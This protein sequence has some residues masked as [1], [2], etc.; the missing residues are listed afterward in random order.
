MAN[1][2]RVTSIS[3]VPITIDANTA[4][5]YTC[6]S[7]TTTVVLALLI[8]NKHTVAVGASVQLVSNTNN[9]GNNNNIGPNA[10]AFIIKDVTIDEKTSLEIMAGQKYVLQVGD[11]IKVYGDN[12]N[13]DVV[14]SYMEMT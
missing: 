9:D 2:F 11:S 4:T 6:P 14:L 10:S 5:I 8:S 3:S 12:T 7:G 1:T 13:L